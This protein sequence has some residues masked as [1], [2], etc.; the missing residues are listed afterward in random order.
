[1]NKKKI[2]SIGCVGI[3]CV[4]V[5]VFIIKGTKPVYNNYS[6]DSKN[7]KAQKELFLQEGKEAT[8]QIE[9]GEKKYESFD[10]CE[11][12]LVLGTDASGNE[13]AE[14]DDYRG[15]MADFLVLAVFNKS[16]DTYAWIQLNRDTM[17]EVQLLDRKGKGEATAEIQ[18]CT[19]HWYGGTKEQSCENTVT[20]V[21]KMFGGLPIDGYYAL[22]MEK[23]AKLNRLVGGVTVTIQDDFSKIDPSMKKGNTVTLNDEQAYIYVHDRYNVGGEDNLSRMSR[24]REYMKSLFDTI[25]KK[26]KETPNT[27]NKIYKGLKKDAV[28]DINGRKISKLTNFVSQ[29]TYL[30]M[31]MLEG[32]ATL[33]K[34]LGDNVEH[35]EY[36]VDEKS[37]ISILTD[38]YGLQEGKE[39]DE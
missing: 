15:S 38:I 12:Y 16:K 18:L 11:T 29:E 35:V 5:M 14:G 2:A 33:G 26:T 28:T 27:I 7:A 31:Y 24:Q 4:M 32:K 10:T 39:S 9:L 19:A 20:A 23:I 13:N 1:M 37:K 8:I 34:A 22:G 30:G 21:S 3:L 17:T 6:T 25:Q 36:H